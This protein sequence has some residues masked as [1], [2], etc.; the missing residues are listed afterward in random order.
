[1]S[2]IQCT[3]YFRYVPVELGLTGT[4]IQTAKSIPVIKI[5]AASMQN[6]K[7]QVLE[8]FA[9]VQEVLQVYNNK[10]FSLYVRHPKF[11]KSQCS[12]IR[13]KYNFKSTKTHYLHFQKWQKIKFLDQKKV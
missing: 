6:V 3:Y 11:H 13:K 2:K 4:R 8:L 9:N 10:T 1:M 7:I 5:P 12:K